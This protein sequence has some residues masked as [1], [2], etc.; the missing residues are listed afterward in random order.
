[1][2]ESCGDFHW[3][4]GFLVGNHDGPLLCPDN[5]LGCSFRTVLQSSG[6]DLNLLAI[7]IE[8]FNDQRLNSVFLE[9]T[10]VPEMG[11]TIG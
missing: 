1:M 7:G 9:L 11:I 5:V 3:L 8:I 10:D 6:T 2:S 4:F